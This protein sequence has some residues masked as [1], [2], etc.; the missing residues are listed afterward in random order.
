MRDE[1]IPQDAQELAAY[2]SIS[3]PRLGDAVQPAHKDDFPH[4]VHSI[5]P[6]IEILERVASALGDREA[7]R[8][9]LNRPIPELEHESPLAVILAGEAGAVATLLDN[10]RNGIPG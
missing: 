6:V 3:L 4:D 5:A 2:L 10:A 9:W 8:A 7:I 1:R